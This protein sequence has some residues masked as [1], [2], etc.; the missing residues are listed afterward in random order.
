M[1]YSVTLSGRGTENMKKILRMYFLVGWAATAWATNGIQEA[2]SVVVTNLVLSLPVDA[3]QRATFLWGQLLTRPEIKQFDHYTTKDWEKNY[4]AFAES[5]VA[6]AKECKLDAVSLQRILEAIKSTAEGLA[7]LPVGA[8]QMQLKE[9]PVWVVVI[10]WESA[11]EG[12][13]L[14][15]IRYFAYDQKTLKHVAFETCM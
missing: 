5:L 10:K 13:Y 1:R 14:R 11:G 4:K 6:K 7:Y 12:A 2:N 15:H 8:Y 9:T 3:E